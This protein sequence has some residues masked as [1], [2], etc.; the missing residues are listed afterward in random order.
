MEIEKLSTKHQAVWTSLTLL[1]DG[2][3]MLGVT[4]MEH[5]GIL[6]RRNLYQVIHG[7]REHGYLIGSGKHLSDRGYYQ[8]R[9]VEDLERTL[10]GLRDT[11]Y[12]LLKTAKTI[13]I[14]FYKNEYGNLLEFEKG[15]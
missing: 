4:L 5:T 13:E 1:E 10:N 11:A 3:R 8:I 15:E 14:S 2:Q 7:L 12:D 9:S 6:E